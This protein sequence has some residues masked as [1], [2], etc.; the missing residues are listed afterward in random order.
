MLK[1]F[2]VDELKAVVLNGGD[3]TQYQE[4]PVGFGENVLGESYTEDV[5]RMM[6][7]VRDHPVTIAK[8]SNATG[9]SQPID[10]PILTPG[11]YKK[12]GEIRVGDF[13]YGGNGHPTKVVG[14]YPQ[15]KQPT[16]RM[17]FSDH[18]QVECSED[19]LWAVRSAYNPKIIYHNETVSDLFEKL[20]RYLHIPMCM[21]VHFP[22]KKQSFDAYIIGFLIGDGTLGQY[23]RFD[24]ADEWIINEIKR[25][26]PDGI[27]IQH[28][29]KTHYGIVTPP[30]KENHILNHLQEIG[31]IGCSS[32]SKFIP[33]TYLFG[34]FE[35]RKALLA[36]LMD[37]DG[38]IDTRSSVSFD[39]VSKKLSQQIKWLVQSFGGTCKV[40]TRYT[41]YTH[42]GE[43]RT[44]QLSY[45]HLIKIG[46]CP[47]RL[48]RK[49]ERWRDPMS[50]QKQAQRIIDNIQYIGEKDSVCIQVENKDGLYLTEE[51]IVTHNTHGS[52]RVAVWWFKSFVNSQVYTGAAPPE[53]NLKKLLWGEIGTII[54]KHPELFKN[55]T[56]TTLHVQRSAQQFLTGV[57]IPSSGTEAQREAKFSGKHSP[58]L[59]FIIDEGDAVPDEVYRGIESCMTGGHARLLIMFNPR[60]EIGEAYRMI[61]DGRANVVRISAFEHPN[62][63]QGDDVIPGAV[64][65][66][67]T[68]RRINQWCRSLVDEEKIDSSC[69]KLPKFLEN[70][71]AKS[72]SGE[73]YL[74]LKPGWY[75]VMEPAFSYM[76]LGEYPAQGVTQLISKEWTSRARTRWDSYVAEHGEIPPAGSRCV[77]GQDV[78][79]FGGDLNASCFRH[80]GFVE[81]I[82][83]WG[84][85]DTVVTGDRAVLLYDSRN[86]M[87]C[88][89]DAT[90]VGAGVGPY[91]H[92][93]DCLTNSV[94]VAS[95]PTFATEIGEFK[96]LRDQLWWQCREWL[97]T[98][99]G[100]MLP[101]DEELLEEL[102]TPTYEIH[103]GKIRVM[104]K[105]TMR[106]LLQRSPNKAD[107]LNL[108][109][110]WDE[111]MLFDPMD[112]DKCAA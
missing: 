80:G 33:K 2:P 38:T 58:H 42:N 47:F 92:R 57:T 100:A 14:V 71:V 5:K 63:I 101:P 43:K 23:V 110:Y 103:K 29:R 84:D 26:L 86:A 12:M 32:N 18:S 21:P 87:I 83:T 39:T 77:M 93:K 31:L 40:S 76:V 94:K 16:Y 17:I 72:Q 53:S 102:H 4:D 45:R 41:T 65:Q 28:Y 75:K 99:P 24:T 54:E 61:R 52:A 73:N 6:E 34:D 59:L 112:L 22:F 25:L 3:Y 79:E 78:A 62:V 46:F 8:S 7:S 97:R 35:Q 90:G 64:T 95:S 67:T 11:G 49:V 96:L 106:E 36:G 81:K 89:V 111:N 55:E 15:G 70:V 1:K 108:T 82:I 37:S 27:N 68:V 48:P 91:M 60:A 105:D 9:K 50:M 44:G 66:Q 20:H 85:V 69:F 88:N 19:H 56:P 13:V 74:P 51:F 109:F 98:D 104:D 10:T 30:G 107:S